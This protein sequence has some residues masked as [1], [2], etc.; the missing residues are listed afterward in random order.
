MR[1]EIGGELKNRMDGKTN[2]QLGY[3]ITGA[4]GRKKRLN[5]KNH[6]RNMD[7]PELNHRRQA[8][9]RP[10]KIIPMLPGMDDP[11]QKS[12]NLTI[13]ARREKNIKERVLR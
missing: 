2:G 7:M 11:L 6:V 1:L 5:K 12:P 4:K 9:E 3:A 13:G 10:L 8:P